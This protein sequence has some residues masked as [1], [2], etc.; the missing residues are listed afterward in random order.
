MRGSYRRIGRSR[1]VAASRSR[2][3]LL[4]AASDEGHSATLTK[5]YRALLRPFRICSL[6][7]TALRVSQVLQT[8]AR[9]LSSPVLLTHLYWPSPPEPEAITQTEVGGGL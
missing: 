8:R 7:S 5:A 9:H 1:S 6:R 2:Q 3:M 4:R